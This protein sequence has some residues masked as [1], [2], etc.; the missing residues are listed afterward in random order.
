MIAMQSYR[1]LI[2]KEASSDLD[3]M[4]E[5]VAGICHPITGHKYV[6][7]I[8]EKLSALRITAD[9][10][11]LSNYEIARRINPLAKTMSIMNRKWTVVYHVE[12]DTVI[13]DRV[14]PSKM[15]IK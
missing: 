9:A 12:F 13:I 6:N 1:I 4:A 11:P 8:L 15:M 10:N 5:Y 14:L 3:D 7:R 2:S